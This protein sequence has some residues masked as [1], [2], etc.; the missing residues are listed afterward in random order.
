MTDWIDWREKE[1]RVRTTPGFPIWTVKCKWDIQETELLERIGSLVWDMFTQRCLKDR[2]VESLIGDKEYELEPQDRG[3]GHRLSD[4]HRYP[5]EIMRIIRRGN[6][7]LK[8]G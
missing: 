1:K 7:K 8:S 6:G 3:R 4:S 5:V 2:E